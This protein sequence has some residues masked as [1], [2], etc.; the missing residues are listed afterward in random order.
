MPKRYDGYGFY[1]NG[2]VGRNAAS[3]INRINNINRESADARYNG[4]PRRN[5]SSQGGAYYP[6]YTPP[7][8]VTAPPRNGAVEQSA[9]RS[10]PRGGES[11][12]SE[13]GGK[14]RAYNE[15]PREGAVRR[16][17]RAPASVEARRGYRANG[18]TYLN[19]RQM[20]LYEKAYFEKYGRSPYIKG[21][22]DGERKVGAAQG[23][24]YR[25]AQS[26]NQYRGAQNQNTAPRAARYR[27]S[28]ARNQNQ[29]QNQYQY[30]N[31]NQSGAY[32]SGVGAGYG[33]PVRD[34]RR[35]AFLYEEELRRRDEERAAAAKRAEAQRIAAREARRNAEIA[36][37]QNAERRR[38]SEIAERDREGMLRYETE[39]RRLALRRREE[40]ERKRR[41]ALIR[42]EKRRARRRRWLTFKMY[43]RVFFITLVATL[44][45]V[46]LIY[47]SNFVKDSSDVS[48]AVRY[49]YFDTSSV[50]AQKNTAYRDGSLCVDFTALA[51]SLGFYTVGNASGLK[52]VIPHGESAPEYIKFTP[53]SPIAVVNGTPLTLSAPA[54]YSGQSLWVSADIMECFSSGI[55][56]KVVN[57]GKVEIRRIT[58][59]DEE[60]KD[61]LG[62]DDK[63]IYEEI[64]LRYAPMTE[65]S[66]EGLAGL[67]DVGSSLSVGNGSD[68]EF[69]SDLSAYEE[70]MDPSDS[71]DFL[72]LVNKN[73]K[74][75]ES[76]EPSDLVDI[77]DADGKAGDGKM[78]LY[79]AKALEA[80][81]IEMRAAGYDD[82]T[83]LDAYRSYGAQK[84][85]F[86][87]YVK[88]EMANRGC[89]EDEARDAVLGYFA[90]AGTDEHQTGL[91]IDICSTP[92]KSADFA[93]EKSYLW[94]K[95]NSWKFGYILRY[96]EDKTEVTGR[97]FEPW[98]YRYVGR[99]AAEKMHGY[100][101]CLEEYL[102][103]GG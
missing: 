65:M 58:V 46:G 23:A 56:F 6:P 70:Y 34:D 42:M 64:K 27:D 35:K 74:A 8:G 84:E 50:R 81:L 78:R 22:A 86:D 75:D 24:Q 3:R 28:R 93:K 52:Y 49:N 12:Y 10:S 45:S 13:R 39:K 1:E 102:T 101:Q 20:A 19:E 48:R 7:R 79:A 16:G 62:D 4:A 100:G 69:M 31:Q 9:E 73:N 43:M 103:S 25:T 77:T 92:A 76:Y 2:S 66:A 63:P 80:M 44:S 54:S 5:V 33:A 95:D 91:A 61:V 32:R 11:R 83:V 85:M 82:V 99:Y 17:E 51:D 21:P 26:P 59:K 55:D 98:H 96:P 18:V 90:E 88:S 37:R 72:M 94:L 15:S 53:D 14:T 71:S 57:S 38:L 29:N 41:L 30:Q 47:Y 67:F 97:S 87:S 68:V 40:A 36:R 89:T 60:G